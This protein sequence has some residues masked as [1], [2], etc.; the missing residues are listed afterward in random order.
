[1]YNV[2]KCGLFYY[3]APKRT[4]DLQ[5]VQ[6]RIKSKDKVSVMVCRN[7]DETEKGQLFFIETVQKLRAFKTK[8]ARNYKLAYSAKKA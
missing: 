6:R 8:A 3:N 7:S 2:D 1:M 5:R 4:N